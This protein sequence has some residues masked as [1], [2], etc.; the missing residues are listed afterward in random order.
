LARRTHLV[1]P[2]LVDHFLI[3]LDFKSN[4]SEYLC[5]LQMAIH[6]IKTYYQHAMIARSPERKWN[7]SN[8]AQRTSLLFYR[9]LRDTDL[10]ILVPDHTAHTLQQNMSILPYQLALSLHADDCA[11]YALL[12]FVFLRHVRL[13]HAGI[14]PL[15]A[16]FS[17]GLNGILITCLS[18]L[19]T[20]VDGGNDYVQNQEGFEQLSRH[21]KSKQP[22]SSS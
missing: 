8:L 1:T 20:K 3:T 2:E 7:Y 17:Q 14:G 6:D 13:A 21:C 12:A 22:A 4:P 5:L 11:A 19:I 16:I 10:S 15:D 9:L 18:A